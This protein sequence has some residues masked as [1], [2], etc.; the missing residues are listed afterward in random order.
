MRDQGTALVC[1]LVSN[2][3]DIL[4]PSTQTHRYTHARMHA[5]ALGLQVLDQDWRV[6][7]VSELKGRI[8]DCV[9]DQNGNH[10]VQKCIECIKPTSHIAFVIEVRM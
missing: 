6:R 8:I 3:L 2:L 10:V 4:P 1:K 5:V 9:A 7:L